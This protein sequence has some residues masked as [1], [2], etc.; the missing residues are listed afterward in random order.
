MFIRA[1]RYIKW[2]QLSD[3][4]KDTLREHLEDQKEFLQEALDNVN[5]NL[6]KL[7]KRPKRKRAVKRKTGRGRGRR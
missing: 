5:Q 6:E 4:E 7:P 2:D 3:A 1:L